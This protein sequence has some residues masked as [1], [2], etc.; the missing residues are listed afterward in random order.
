MTDIKKIIASVEKLHG[1]SREQ[2]SKYDSF[3]AW[4]LRQRAIAAGRE[5]SKILKVSE[6]DPHDPI[7]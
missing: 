6:D 3:V 7:A 5:P 4:Q 2:T 1:G